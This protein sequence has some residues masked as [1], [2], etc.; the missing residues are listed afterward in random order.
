MNIRPRKLLM[1]ANLYIFLSIVYY[2]IETSSLLNPIAITLV[3]LFG[4]HIFIAKKQTKLI[5]PIIFLVVNLYMVLALFSEF[6]EFSTLS[7]EAL[8][9]L[10]VGILYLGLNI[11]SAIFILQYHISSN[12]QVVRS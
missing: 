10:F 4:V 8:T 11:A 2:W 6:S 12:I 7:N 5:L 3:L 1:L 9:L